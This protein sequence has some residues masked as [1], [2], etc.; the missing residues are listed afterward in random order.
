VAETE[1]VVGVHLT[2]KMCRWP[3]GH[4]GEPGFSFCGKPRLA[5][6]PYC[7]EHCAVAYRG[8]AEEAA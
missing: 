3:I 6:R 8:K 2:E 4:P 5:G 7:G 1:H